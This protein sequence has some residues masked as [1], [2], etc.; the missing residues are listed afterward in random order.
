M[1]EPI[2]KIEGLKT[3]FHTDDGIVKAVDDVS[4]SIRPG[5]TLGVVGESGSGKSV[6]SLT[7]MKLL[8]DR[9]S[10]IAGGSISF[11]GKDLLGISQRE[12]TN[13]RGS[14][15]AM[16]FQEPMTALNPV[17]RVGDQVGEAIIR[18]EGV[19]KAEAYKR[20]ISLFNEVGIPDPENRIHSYPHEMS[21][22]QKQR[23]MIAMA[24]ACNPK[25][26]VADEPTTALDVTIQ[27]QILDLLRKLRDER[28]MA[29]LF[30]T[31]DLGVIA[32]IADHVAVMF[33]GKL[34]EYGDVVDIFR[35]PAHPYTKGL[36][37]CRPRLE[38]PYRILPTVNEFM[39][40]WVED[41]ETK[42][43]EKFLT[44]ER[45]ENLKTG[46]RDKL[47]DC[48]GEPM[49]SVRDLA[50]HFPLKK[51]FL[52]KVTH[53]VKAVDGISF[54]VW[55]GQTLGLVGE[56]GCGKTTTGRAILRLVEPTSGDVLF[57]GQNLRGLS[58]SEMLPIRRN[59]QIIFQD[60]Y[61]SLNPRLTVEQAITEP[62]LVHGIGTS[63]KERTSRAAALLEEV[64][65]QG[66]YL[67]RFPHEFSGGQRQRICIA[68]TL[69]LE[70]KFIICDESVSALDV[71]VQAQVLNLL[72]ELQLKRGLTYIFI[73]HDLSVVKF[74]SDVM[75]V[76]K[77]GVIVEAGPSDAIYQAPQ[78]QYTRDLISAIPND[79]LANIEMRQRQRVEAAK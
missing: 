10:E 41:G 77:D 19:S 24:L 43:K 38:S 79:D 31:H 9:V 14:E 33:R 39:D 6:T 71:S 54:D 29:I 45:I 76:M 55:P 74:M 59:L 47:V 1:S 68:R 63:S 57:Q 5:E 27:A 73:S 51:T 35:A 17:Y 32:E 7:I 25:L 67:R 78:Q 53:W 72:K 11:L 26:L 65:L 70:P 21:G 18:H 3:Y 40:H 8:P 16:I 61:S 15:I 23:V 75:C 69:A 49:L 28:Q 30:I 48:E 46:G 2:L 20:T 64:G 13:L 66:S 36:L 4:F 42:M 52:G 50:V 12:M 60:P 62:M 37:A 34:V 22:G 58:K 44:E 56:S